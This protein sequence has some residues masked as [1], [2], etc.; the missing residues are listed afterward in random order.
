M[1]ELQDRALADLKEHGPSTSKQIAERL[2]VKTSTVAMALCYSRGDSQVN[3]GS[4]IYIWPDGAG[5]CIHRPNGPVV[6]SLEAVKTL[7]E[8]C[9]FQ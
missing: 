3:D 1:T 8:R 6:W 2:G 4:T 9:P 5:R 7:I